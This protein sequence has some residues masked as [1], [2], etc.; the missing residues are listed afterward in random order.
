MC[1]HQHLLSFY[2]SD[3]FL[4]E[5]VAEFAVPA[6]HD[7]ESVI[8][9]ATPAHRAAF[10]DAI[11]ARGVDLR[12]AAVDGCYQAIDAR[13]LLS[14]FMLQGAPDRARFE[15]AIGAVLD[16]ASADGRHP[17]VYGEMVALLLADGDMTATLALEDLWSELA[18]ERDFSLMCAYPLK[19]FELAGR[20]AFRRICS[21]HSTVIPTETYSLATT[22]DEQQRVVA[23]LQQ[24][25]AALRAELRRRRRRAARAAGSV[26]L[27]A[28]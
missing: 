18:A 25:A 15:E 8:V 23:E 10:A 11:S 16:R 24:E 2:E 9:I 20:D 22:A 26:L 13:E 17:K 27:R 12:A 19:S 14:T 6:L 28:G 1:A 3:A 7:C 5:S 21:Q 4:V